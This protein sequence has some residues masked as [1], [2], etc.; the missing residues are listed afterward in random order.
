MKGRKLIETSDLTSEMISIS[1][2]Y[3]ALMRS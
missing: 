2:Q 1:E 3:N